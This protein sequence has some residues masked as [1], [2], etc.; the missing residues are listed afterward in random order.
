MIHDNIK[1][2]C[3]DRQIVS[4]SAI[5]RRDCSTYPNSQKFFRI[6][7]E[8]GVKSKEGMVAVC[9]KNFWLFAK[10]IKSK[11]LIFG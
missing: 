2:D 11:V 10:T 6:T 1:W 8:Q 4:F 5:A 3:S 9:S 7:H